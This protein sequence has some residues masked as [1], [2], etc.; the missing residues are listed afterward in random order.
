MQPYFFPYYGYFNLID[1]ALKWVLMHDE[2]SVV[3][4]G[5]TNTLQVEMNTKASKLENISKI[6]PDI[7]SIYENLIKLNYENYNLYP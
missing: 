7:Q 1:L 3:I 4:P 5:A 2:V 6:M